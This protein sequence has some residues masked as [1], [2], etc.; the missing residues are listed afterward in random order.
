MRAKKY[1]AIS[2][3][4]LQ[5]LFTYDKETGH[6]TRKVQCGTQLVGTRAGT[7]CYSKGNLTGRLVGINKAQYPEHVLVW[8]YVYG[9]V[10]QCQ[11]D[12]VDQDPSNNRLDNLRLAPNNQM[13][14]CQNKKPSRK[15]KLG[16]VGVQL[17]EKQN[18]Y[19][20]YIT[21]YK[22]HYSLGGYATLEEAVAAREKARKKLHPFST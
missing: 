6:L 2:Q 18:R 21:A 12:H 20:A 22:K 8:L 17:N 13:D 14:Q 19:Y 10:P 16:V 4:L 9:H 11:I 1:D 15:N 7:P 5:E 3:A